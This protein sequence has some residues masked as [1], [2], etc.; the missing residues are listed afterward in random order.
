VRFPRH[1]DV[2]VDATT[3]EVIEQD[4]CARTLSGL[5][6]RAQPVGDVAETVV[7]GAATPKTG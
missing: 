3:D 2:H 5:E 7:Q 6:L 4:V 1:V